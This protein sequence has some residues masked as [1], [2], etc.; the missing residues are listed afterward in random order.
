MS[1]FFFRFLQKCC[2]MRKSV[3]G[4]NTKIYISSNIRV[5]LKQAKIVTSSFPLLK[6]F[7]LFSSETHTQARQG[8]LRIGRLPRAKSRRFT[9]LAPAASIGGLLSVRQGGGLGYLISSV[10]SLL[11]EY[12][13][14]GRCWFRL[15]THPDQLSS[16]MASLH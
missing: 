14:E 13:E 10:L 12:C 11:S 7:L 16:P 9:A 15:L 5:D 6:S 1:F 3:I 4:N 8:S 2:D